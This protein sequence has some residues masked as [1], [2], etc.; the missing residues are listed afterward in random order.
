MSRIS[1]KLVSGK[2]VYVLLMISLL[3]G[4]GSFLVPTVQ[5]AQIT[6][7]SLELS[8]SRPG[9]VATYKVAFDITT[10]STLGSIK[11]EFCANTPIFGVPCT[12]P[13]GFDVS[14]A[15]LSGQSGETGFSIGASTTS[16]VLILTRPPAAT[17]GGSVVYT[18]SGVH[19]ATV[20]ASSY[21]RYSIFPTSDASGPDTDRGG[22]AYALN[23]ALSVSAEVPPF[24]IFCVGVTISGTDC[25][26]AA[27]DF[28]DLGQFSTVRASR[29]QTQMVAA[30]NAQNGYTVRISGQTMTSGNNIIPSLDAPTPSAPGTNQFGIN[31]RANTNPPG[32]AD[33]S[34]PGGGSVQG[35][36]NI[37]N[38]FM[39]I[40]G[41]VVAANNNVEDFH[42][43]TVNYLV[44]INSNQAPGVYNSSFTYTALGNF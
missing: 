24:L 39:Y 2:F 18:L 31:L 32:G 34:G 41:D 19:S 21:A 23:D 9:Q 16:N 33:P 29:G 40:S 35:N 20:A 6:N 7:R 27:G 13:A 22:I 12:A 36:Y 17:P 37:P 5:G 15:T 8:D 14:G 10:A 42:K 44:N 26:T 25:S 4:A 1:S 3:L 38:R 28:V 30:T 11:V 43:F